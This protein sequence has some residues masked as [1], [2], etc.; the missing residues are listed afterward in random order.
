MYFC[1]ILDVTF[2][3]LLTVTTVYM[4]CAVEIKGS[5]ARFISK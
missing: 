1:E 2:Y 4:E 3:H 5:L